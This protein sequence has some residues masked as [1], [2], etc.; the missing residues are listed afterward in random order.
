MG[1]LLAVGARALTMVIALVCG[2]LT[3]RMIIG[4]AGVGSFAST[5][6]SRR[7]RRC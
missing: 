2:V 7:S 6:C 1:S 3:T 5:R 4:D